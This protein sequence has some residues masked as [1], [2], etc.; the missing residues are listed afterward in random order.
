[1]ERRELARALSNPQDI[2]CPP[3]IREPWSVLGVTGSPGVGKSCI[4]DKIVKSWV[5]EGDKVAVL[6]IDPS[7]PVT[8][9][10]LLGDRMRMSSVDANDS[11]F[12]RSIATRNVPGGIP[13]MLDRMIDIL[14]HEGWRKI[15]IETVG[16]GQSE[17]RVVAVA[18][19]ILLVEGPG[20]GDIIQAEKAGIIELS[21]IIAVNKS[22]LSGAEKVAQEI[23]LSLEMSDT[24]PPAILLCSAESGDG[25]SELIE[26]IN[27]LPNAKG[28]SIA[29]ARERLLSANQEILLNHPDF[30]DVLKSL[31]ADEISIADAMALLKGA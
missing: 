28:P 4:V 6:A 2:S 27:D 17:V 1:M 24:K 20:R 7:S 21:D 18:D 3:R 11:V 30:S 31:V 9:G 15:I 26:T 19:R 16:S 8:G 23:K 12:F 25:I 5:D 13:A 14:F 29:K 10:A 22:D